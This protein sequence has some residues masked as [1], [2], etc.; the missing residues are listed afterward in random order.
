MRFPTL[1]VI[2][3]E[4]ALG[5]GPFL[6]E[7]ADHQFEQD[8]VYLEGYDLKPSEIFKRQCYLTG[9][10]D[11]VAVHASYLPVDHILWATNFPTTT[12]TWPTSAAALDRNLEGLTEEQRGLVQ[13]GNAARLYR[14]GS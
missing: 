4:S 10:Y 1:Q 12:S 2:F 14:E 3:A 9:W 5:W 6:L 7:Y 11:P 8:R 13:W